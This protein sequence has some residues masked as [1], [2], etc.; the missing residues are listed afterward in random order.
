MTDPEDPVPAEDE[1][2]PPPEPLLFRVVRSAIAPSVLADGGHDAPLSPRG[3]FLFWGAVSIL[4][5]AVAI[6]FIA[7]LA[8]RK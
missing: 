4:V 1:A 5:L 8:T 6:L 2:E 3:R 7:T